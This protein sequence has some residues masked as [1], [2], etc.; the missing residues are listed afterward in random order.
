MAILTSKCSWAL[1]WDI[2]KCWGWAAYEMHFHYTREWAIT[3]AW[4]FPWQCKIPTPIILCSIL[5]IHCH[6]HLYIASS[7]SCF[8]VPKSDRSEHCVCWDRSRCCVFVCNEAIVSWHCSLFSSV[9]RGKSRENVIWIEKW[10]GC[11]ICE[12][13][14]GCLNVASCL[15]HCE[16]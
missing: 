16:T 7:A 14:T 8:D 5:I 9:Q 1:R 2:L 12:I 6:W 15:K 4:A 11:L 10:S 3:M 13:L